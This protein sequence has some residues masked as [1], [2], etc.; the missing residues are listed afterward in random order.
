MEAF[1]KCAPPW[2][3]GT[4]RGRGWIRLE[5]VESA[6]QTKEKEEPQADR[7]S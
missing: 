1:V 4:A 3:R 7:F 2:R 6:E 5:E